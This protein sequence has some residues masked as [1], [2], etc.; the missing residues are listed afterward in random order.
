MIGPVFFPLQP[1]EM[2]MCPTQYLLSPPPGFCPQVCPES[3]SVVTADQTS[4][5]TPAALMRPNEEP[6]VAAPVFILSNLYL[7]SLFLTPDVHSIPSSPTSTP[8]VLN[9]YW[10]LVFHHLLV[11]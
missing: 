2:E 11:S 4:A 5:P 7:S 3:P 9:P 10:F 1:N 8:R 6:Q